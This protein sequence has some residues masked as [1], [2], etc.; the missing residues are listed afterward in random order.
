MPEAKKPAVK[1]EI[2]MPSPEEVKK[3]L[4]EVDSFLQKLIFKIGRA[5]V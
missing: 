2:K 1:P 5:H 4:A 3:K